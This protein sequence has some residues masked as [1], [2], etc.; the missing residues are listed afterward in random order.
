MV[1]GLVGE[2][3][4]LAGVVFQIFNSMPFLFVGLA[5]SSSFSMTQS[6]CPLLWEGISNFSTEEVSLWCSHNMWTLSLV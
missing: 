4:I 1:G 5:N 3:P 6:K 2:A